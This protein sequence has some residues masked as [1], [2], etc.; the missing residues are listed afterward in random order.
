MKKITFLIGSLGGGGAERVTIAL[1]NY[2]CQCNY[3]IN[4]IVFSKE[5]N[6]YK[7]SSNINVFYLSENKK[8][9]FIVLK[10][11]SELKKYLKEQTPDYV[12]SL[13]LGYQYLLIGGLIKKYKFILSERNTPN[14]FYKWYQ[15]ICVKYCYKKAY[16]VVFQT[17]DAQSFFSKKI[18]NKSVIIPNPIT[19]SLPSPYEG[20]RRKSIVAVNRLSKQKNIFMLLDAFKLVLVDFPD[21]ILEIYGK[22]EQKDELENYATKIGILNSVKFLGQKQNVHSYILD[23]ALFVSSSDFEG[24]SNSMLEAMA[25]GLPVVCTDCPVGGARMMIVNNVN[26]ILTSV[27]DSKEFANSIIDLLKNPEKAAFLGKNASKLRETLRIENIA[28]E[29]DKLM[30]L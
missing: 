14:L 23:A 18:R 3:E 2:F 8:N 21:Y 4:F 20:I 28:K 13:G 17:K 6:N 15:L 24:M 26:G 25:I 29:W 10:R 1:A 22:G 9:K 5:N 16:R 19:S 27:G 7:V 12:V 30:E 11:I